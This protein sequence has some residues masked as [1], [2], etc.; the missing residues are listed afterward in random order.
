MYLT[1]EEEK[2]LEGEYGEALG[3]AYRV[4]L[5][6]G[7]LLEA[8]RLIRIASAHISGVNYSNLGEVGL[9]FLEE[10]SRG[11][12]VSVYTT[13]NPCGA[14]LY[15]P[16]DYVP[17]LFL[18]RQRR[19]REA[20]LRMGC[21]E[22]FTCAPYEAENKPA[23]GSHVSWAESSASI[24]ANSVLGVWTNRESGLSALASAVSGKTPEGGVHLEENRRPGYQLVVDA[25][26]RDYIDYSL[27]GLLA[28]SRTDA[29]CIAFVGMRRPGGVEAKH[30]SAAIGS[31][32]SSSMFVVRDGREAGVETERL[33]QEELDEARREFYSR[34][35][36]GSNN[37][38]I[39]G[40][41]FYGL[42][43]VEELARDVAG[44][45]A[46]ARVLLQVSNSVY[47]EARRRGLLEALKAS[48]VGVTRGACGTL[49]PV[50]KW[51]E[52]DAVYTDSLKGA[53]YLRKRGVK[54]YVS[55]PRQIV[56]AAMG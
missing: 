22:S 44:R 52:A 28:A 45:R 13:V 23:P 20:F 36:P 17:E 25:R 8:K 12:R 37:L 39:L 38:F 54:A 51:I 26:L 24:Y 53:F 56:R 15:E 32:G 47:E 35:E 50:D 27:T 18:D 7:E 48:G 42:R 55:D 9:E 5:A 4:L 29:T 41:P 1:N 19:I 16:A 46:R 33:G 21:N 34:P 30:L 43:E 2:A 10:F 11:A 31:A 40:C 6:V 3:Q 14:D 49:T